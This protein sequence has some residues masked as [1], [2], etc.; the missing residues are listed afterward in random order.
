MSSLPEPNKNILSKRSILNLVCMN[1]DYIWQQLQ[2]F[3]Q[4]I[5]AKRISGVWRAGLRRPD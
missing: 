5:F 1:K 3:L 2:A 4:N